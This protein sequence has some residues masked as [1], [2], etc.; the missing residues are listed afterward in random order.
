MPQETNL[1]VSPYFDDFNEDK[2]FNRVL[3]K[4]GIPVQARELTQLQTILQNQI[5]KFGQHFFKEGS[6]VIPGQIGYDSSYHAVEL[7]DTFLGIP[8]S[9]YLDKLVGKTIKGEVSGVEATVVNYILA[10]QS[11]R[12]HNTLYVKYSKSGNDF[13][14]NV[15][16]DGENLVTSSDIEYGISR[17]IANNPFATTIALNATSLGTAATVQEG[18]Y[19][20]RGYFVKVA[21]QTV[22]VEQYSDNPSYRVGLFIDENVVSAFDDSTL[23]D[24]AAGFS[25]FAAPGA[26]RF[27][28]KPTLIKKDLDDF[29][30]ANFIELLRLNKGAIQRMVKKTDYNL[31]ADEFARRTFDESGNYYVK[32]FGVQVRESLNDRQGN[33]G[34]YFKDQKTSQGNEPSSDSMIIQVSPGKAYVRGYEIEKVGSTFIDVEKPRTIKKLENQ[35]FAFDKVS[36][37][38]LNRVYGTPFVGMGVNHTVQLRGQRIGATHSSAAGDQIGDARVYDYKLESTGYTG[39]SSVYELFLWDIQ[40]FT[41]LT[42]N[43][44]LTAP[45]GSLIEGQRSG[46][47]GH[48]KTAASNST[49]LTLTSTGGNFIVDEPIRVN[50]VDDSKTITAVT[51]FSIDDVKSI[52]QQV[53]GSTFNADTV[54]SREGSPAPAGTEYTITTGGTCTVAGNRFTRGI[55]VGDI[56]KYQKSGET[57]PTFNRV[58]AVNPNGAQITLVALGADVAGVCQKELPSG[59]TLV[60]SD[61]KI[62][63]PRI[64]DGKD[65]S[66]ISDMPKAVISSLDLTSSEISTRQRF[67]FTPSGGTATASI[68]STNEFFEVFDEERYNLTYSNGAVQILREANLVFSADRK[69]VTL[70][71]LS[72]NN[73]AV[74]TATV[75][76]TQ[77]ISQKKTLDQCQKIIINRSQKAGSGTGLLGD[78]L[79]SSN[80]YG[81]R[82]QDKEICL[83]FPDIVR[84]LAVFE[85]STTGDPNLPSISLINRS[86]DLT[87]TIKGELVIGENSGATARVVTKT[88]ESVDIIYT[89]DIQFEKEEIANFQSSGIVGGVSLVTQGDKDITKSFSFD[90]GQ[91][92]EFYDYGR[93]IRKEGQAEPQKR[94]AIVFDH[95]VLDGEVGDFA[96]ANSYSSDNYEF[97]M[98]VFSGVPLSDFIDARPRIN[99]YTNTSVSPFDYDSRSFDTGGEKPPVIVG[100]DVVTL[101]YSHYLARIDKLFLSKDGFFELKKGAPASISDVVPPSEPAGSFNVATISVLPYARNAKRASNIKSARHKRYTMSDIGRLET[102]L[103]NVEFY[104][105]L[106]LL[107]TDTASLNIVDAKTGLDR[108]KSGFFVDN[109]RSHNGQALSH[110][111]SRC[112]IDKKAGELRPSHYTH[113]LDLLLGSEQVIGIGVE[114]DPAADLTQ[115][116]DL[117]TND[118]KRSG[119]VVTLNYTEVPYI[120]Q[121]L[122]TRTENVNPFAV[123]TWIGGVELNPNS[124]VWLNE[125]QLESNVVD[126][127][128]GFTQAMQQLAVDPNTGLAPIQWG[129]WEE[130]W[131]SVDVERNVL[132]SDVNSVV[133]GSNTVTV[134]RGEEGHP[135]TDSRPARITTTSFVDEFIDTVEETITIDRGLTRSGIQFQVNESIDTQ[136]LGNK[137]V[138]SELI[139]FMRSRNIEFIATRV[140]PRTQFYTF[141]DGQEVNKYVS[142]KLIE[143]SM[144]QGVFQ[145]GETIRGISDDWQ[146]SANGNA[147]SISFRAAQPNHKFGAYNDPT[148][149]YAVNPYSDTVGISSNYSATSSIVNVDTGSLQQEV[150][151]RFQGFV[152]KNMILRGETSGAEAKV[153][154]VRL[155]SDEKGALI[156]SLFIPE[157]SLPSAP[158]FRTGTNTFRLSSSSVDSRSPLDRASSAET[159][160]NSRGTLNTLQEDVLSV[161]TADIQQSTLNDSTTISNQSSNVFQQT[162]GFDTTRTTEQV[163]WFDPLAESFE[164]TEANGV[165]VSSVDIFFQT[166][167][168]VI[169]VTCQIRTMQTGF[170][171]RTIVPFGEVVL[172][173][174]QVNISEFGT[175]ATRF[176]FPSPVFLEGGGGEYAL[177][178]ISQSNNYNVFIAQMGEED[179]ADRNLAESERRI[180]SQQP[181]LGS[182]FKSQNGSTWTP[183]Q[184]E[185]LKFLMNKCEFVSGPGALKLYNPE[186]GIGNKERPILRQNPIVFNSQEV[187]IALSGD[188]SSNEITDFPIGSLMK[189]TATSSQG[190][191]VAHLGKLGTISHQSGTGVGLV[192]ATYSNVPLTTITGN[193]TGGV[194][195][196]VISGG[197]PTV[198]S[199]NVT[200][201]G[202]GYKTGDVL[203][204]SV[205][206]TGR[207]LRFFV[208]SITDVNSIILNRVQGEFNTSST[209][210]F[211]RA[212]GSEG[213]LNNGT[214]TA[215][216]N[217]STVKDGLHI[218]VS[219]RNHGMHAVNN[220]VTISG[221]VG[222]STVTSITE[223]YAHNSTSPIKVSDISFLGDFEGLPVSGTNPGYV[224]IGNEVIKYTSAANNELKGTVTRG[225]DNTTAE[226]HEVGKTVRKYEGAGVSLRRINTTHNLADSS[227]AP[228]MDGY[229][230]KLDVTD[231]GNGVTRDGT[232]SDKKLKIAETEIGGGKIVRATQN[233]QFE[234]FTSLVEFMVPSDTTLDSSI[235]TVSG[236]S[237]GGS[238][239]SF[240]DQGFESVSL[241]GITH[242]TSPR[243]IASKV[244]E[245]DK[246]TALPG[247]K[248]FTQEL[249]FNTQDANVSPVVDLDRLSI[250]T[251]T[252]RIDKP[253]SDYK[254]DSRV[255]SMLADPNAAIYITKVVQL[256]NPATS[257]Q[258]KFAAFR[259]NTNDLRVLY[260]LIRTD[261]VIAD[262]PYELFP[263]FKNLTDTTGDGFGDQLINARDSDGTPDRFVPA[264]RTLKEFRDYQYTAND[265]V[266]FTGFQIKVIMAGTSQAYVPRIRDFRSIALA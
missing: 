220:K 205:G 56:V 35:V 17:V 49:S 168:D 228:T 182:L 135:G 226:T 72:Q 86:A 99:K 112:S 124:D 52:Y 160:F 90:D 231:T 103:K 79:T 110:P 4:P 16:N 62:I 138:S 127:D 123:I 54:L 50:G 183:S 88:A 217:T 256:E 70:K 55:K 164:I 208:N 156:G 120:S 214:P 9:E 118:L 240:A 259:H 139:P 203:G 74:F 28:L 26:D 128:A 125:K 166:K 224:Q 213:D 161:R 146:T 153:T 94:L 195:T 209:L 122:A 97:D 255:N 250:I 76:R 200:T 53:S 69:S 260:R 15:F 201:R 24:N 157:A 93:L 18:V 73:P 150:L 100:D 196:I 265:L 179:I 43:S 68:T 225:I 219:H 232:T 257:L 83:N 41:T 106:S 178:L 19:F 51:E 34:V 141:F 67:T 148:I 162:T 155:I 32:Q 143:I 185:D 158:E 212:N 215:I 82:V 170:P 5:E 96:S 25:N 22:I 48:L 191:V 245:Q 42:I 20:I 252:N 180:V 216:T 134:R 58:S 261:G 85:S 81:T 132:S 121:P 249:I 63:R 47:R 159:S 45:V 111:C 107:E 218:H 23:F 44:A 130:V 131:S 14:T 78:G 140:Q 197:T 154:D 151:G 186:L 46:A 188:T 109:F 210:R 84:V 207:N 2:N 175:I 91:R 65:S 192:N 190:N 3:F 266:E 223:E 194:A 57:D 12:G 176:T 234:T 149:V 40:T 31:L 87:N 1:N 71:G 145:V 21:T 10:T 172:D 126:I 248:S 39:A 30:D 204:A 61:F 222:I 163:Q 236:T 104:T 258:V 253:V 60:T 167:D 95:Y 142:P 227:I 174:E 27:Q 254:T 137:L 75:K 235:R 202:H 113:A 230:I 33:N 64:I 38:K 247:G 11:E 239:V 262:S 198:G 263:G 238:E 136:S 251:T 6:M 193:G 133:Q 66:F 171:T 233:I 77:V 206:D 89:N 129:G 117:Q 115:V 237:A 187:K 8:I 211:V 189:Q 242:L 119:D 229:H 173:P 108:F 102:R 244:N 105:Q 7:E 101:G 29:S 177:T 37:I 169:P 147:A 181:Y 199:V 165:F 152:G 13:A 36:K 116:A 246:L 92:P 59:S 264:S 98:P 243:I 144:Q 184:F 241:S 80:V 114:A 221:V